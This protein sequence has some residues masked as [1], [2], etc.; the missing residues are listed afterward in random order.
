M[1]IRTQNKESLV[2]VDNF[3]IVQD[4]Y[5]YFYLINSDVGDN[6]YYELGE[7]KTKERAL[8]VLDEIQKAIENLPADTTIH[9][10][11]MSAF[12]L[13]KCNFSKVFQMPEE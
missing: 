10:A 11:M 2:N 3:S 7:Y 9:E 4:D 12:D 8:E 5:S 6:E 1:W 13:M